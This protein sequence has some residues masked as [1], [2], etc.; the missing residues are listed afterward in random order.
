MWN[1]LKRRIVGTGSDTENGQRLF[2]IFDADGASTDALAE[3]IKSDLRAWGYDSFQSQQAAKHLVQ[4]ASESAA[5]DKQESAE[6]TRFI[7]AIHKNDCNL[8]ER[9]AAE[10]GDGVTAD[11]IRWYWSLHSV[12][13]AAMTLFDE[14]LQGRMWSDRQAFSLCMEDLERDVKRQLPVFRHTIANDV[15]SPLPPELKRRFASFITRTK[16]N[17]SAFDKWSSRLQEASSMNAL[18]RELIVSGDF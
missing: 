18:V 17:P 10:R 11:D 15:D 13:R 1:Q 6:H 9:L 7:D 14:E 4:K 3:Q 16:E 5:S 2:S 8:L 12:V